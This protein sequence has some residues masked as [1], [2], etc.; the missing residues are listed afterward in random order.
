MALAVKVSVAEYDPVLKFGLFVSVKLVCTVFGFAE[1][2]DPPPPVHTPA[3]ILTTLVCDV[4]E[5]V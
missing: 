2:Q 4:V 1:L 5:V 3:P